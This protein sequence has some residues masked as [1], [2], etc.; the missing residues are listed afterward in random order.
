M[1]QKTPR[2]LHKANEQGIKK[3]RISIQKFL[4]CDTNS[5]T[6]FCYS[7]HQSPNFY[8]PFI[9]FPSIR[10][11]YYLSYIPFSLAF[12]LSFRYNRYVLSCIFWFVFI[13]MQNTTPANHFMYIFILIWSFLYHKPCTYLTKRRFT[14]WTRK[15]S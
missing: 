14:L 10:F 4:F 7:I 2:P 15:T 3:G 6:R 8:K 11:S 5:M 12:F 9:H 13:S 1:K